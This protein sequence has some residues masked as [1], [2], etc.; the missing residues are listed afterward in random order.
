MTGCRVVSGN[1]PY[2]QDRSTVRDYHL[3][4]AS[5]ENPVGAGLIKRAPA[6]PVSLRFP[7]HSIKYTAPCTELYSLLEWPKLGWTTLRCYLQ[8]DEEGHCWVR[9]TQRTGKLAI[10]CLG[11]SCQGGA[12][13]THTHTSSPLQ[14]A[15]IESLSKE[16]P[17]ALS[18]PS[19]AFKQLLQEG[20]KIKN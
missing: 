12:V 10:I 17:A 5:S 8:K 11:G 9:W 15:V 3:C 16:I 13:H 18:A 19:A 6:L 1:P 14:P 4:L 2:V 20:E 7:V